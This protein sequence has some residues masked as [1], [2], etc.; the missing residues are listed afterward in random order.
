M[1][2]V[3]VRELKQNLSAILRRVSEKNEEIEITSHGV[4]VARLSPV[5]RARPLRKK[6]A[7]IWAELD[8]LA[9]EIGRHWQGEPSAVD[10]IREGRR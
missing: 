7:A 5:T 2:T 6:D 8:Q 3:G 4:V 9:E 10:A 1:S